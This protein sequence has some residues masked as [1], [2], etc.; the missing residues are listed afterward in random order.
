VIPPDTVYQEVADDVFAYATDWKEAIGDQAVGGGA[1]F[2]AD[3][4]ESV[5]VGYVKANKIRSCARYF[6]GFS[7]TGV[8]TG[9]DRYKLRREP[10]VK[11]PEFP[12][13]RAH[14]IA[15]AKLGPTATTAAP[16]DVDEAEEEAEGA[17]KINKLTSPF[18]GVDGNPMY[19]AGYEW[20]MVTVSYKSFGRTR[21]S[22]DDLIGGY[23]DEWRRYTDQRTESV[24]ETLS[25][26][27]TGSGLRYVETPDGVTPRSKN[28]PVDPKNTK[29]PMD[30][31]EYMP[32]EVITLRWMN[33]PHEYISND[34][35]YSLDPVKIRA[36]EGKVNDGDFLEI[37]PAGTLLMMPTK[38]EPV[39]F[40][41]TP[42]DTAETDADDIVGGWNVTLT[43]KRFDPPKGVAASAFRGHNLFPWRGA[44]AEGGAELGKWLYCTRNGDPSGPPFIPTADFDRI[45]QHVDD[46]S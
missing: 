41:V 33:V 8:G 1:T 45:F 20:C 2:S 23:A 5:R 19:Y 11:D 6:L 31:W 14:T 44:G 26:S 28:P 35:V 34:D 16:G 9:D 36:C 40:P 29:V 30:T 46:P 15:F 43:F 24:L 32:Q 13:L 42:A 10:P 12:Q 17:A 22:P 21:F 7:Y 3:G 25:V 38:Y 27:G 4:Q 37:Y 18:L 39:L